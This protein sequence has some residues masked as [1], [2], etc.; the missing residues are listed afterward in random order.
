MKE[1]L[2]ATWVRADMKKQG[3]VLTGLST[4]QTGRLLLSEIQT[5]GIRFHTVQTRMN[6]SICKQC[7]N[8]VS[9]TFTLL[10]KRVSDSL[11]ML[12]RGSSRLWFRG[13]MTGE[14]CFIHVFKHWWGW[15]VFSITSQKERSVPSGQGLDLKAHWH[16]KLNSLLS[17]Y[18]YCVMYGL[19]VCVSKNKRYSHIRQP[20]FQQV[21]EHCRLF[22]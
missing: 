13:E 19:Y 12:V 6:W 8:N 11:L 10:M 7:I 14:K 5:E 21:K 18:C 20:W 4:T 3:L 15:S 22:A 2:S 16:S 9:F 17:V 1:A